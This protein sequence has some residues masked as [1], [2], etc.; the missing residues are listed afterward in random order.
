MYL[1]STVANSPSHSI[2]NRDRPGI[3]SVKTMFRQ[4]SPWIFVLLPNAISD[5]FVHCLGHEHAYRIRSFCGHSNG[6]LLHIGTASPFLHPPILILLSSWLCL[7]LP[8]RCVAVRTGRTG[9]VGHCSGKVAVSSETENPVLRV[10]ERNSDFG[11]ANLVSSDPKSG[12][13]VES[14]RYR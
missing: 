12:T 1:L 3:T 2:R 11:T 13:V 4:P 6:C 5:F 7:R 9:M 8:A 14:A 10:D